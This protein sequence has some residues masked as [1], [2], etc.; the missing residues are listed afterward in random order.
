VGN[1]LQ[2]KVMMTRWRGG[3][4]NPWVMMLLAFCGLSSPA[5][6]QQEV[7]FALL[8][9]VSASMG[10]APFTATA[11]PASVPEAPT[12][13]FLD[14]TNSFLFA[15]NAALC[16]ADFVVTRDNLRS[17]GQELNPVTRLFAGSTAGLAV[18]FAGESAGVVGL[19]YLF[20]KTGH[21]RLERMVSV[22]NI[23]SSASA[24][25][26]GLAHR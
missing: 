16:A 1:T 15:T 11:K 23:G 9:P 18:N 26:F 22:V 13:R 3:V 5:L 10:P 19:S 7:S 4:L 24:V 12:H 17:G 6:A 25:A 2:T 21:H 20:H 8:R 14:R